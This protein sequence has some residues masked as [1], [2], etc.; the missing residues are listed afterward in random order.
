MSADIIAWLRS[1]EGEEWSRAR[2]SWQP[3]SAAP[4][5][6]RNPGPV[7][8][9]FDPTGAPPLTPEEIAATE[10][11]ALCAVAVTGRASTSVRA[12]NATCACVREYA[13]H[14]WHD[15]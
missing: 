15:W 10:G 6:Y 5:P 14:G 2:T 13:G 9:A 12:A 7:N 11:A 1:P 4:S 3:S 8:P